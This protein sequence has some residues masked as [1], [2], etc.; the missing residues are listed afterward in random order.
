NDV[1]RLPPEFLRKGRFDEIFFVDLPDA[2]TRAE[3]FRI[4]L[5]SRGQ[6]AG[7]FD[8]EALAQVTDGFSGSGIEGGGVAA[9]YGAF[10][11]AGKLS[12]AA[13]IEEARKTR[14]LSVTRREDIDA[15]RAWARERTV[16]AN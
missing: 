3:V 12:L 9:L 7:A 14:P 1:E 8:L 16:P 5:A 6:D 13:L 2:A 15:L 10:A 11:A 4:H